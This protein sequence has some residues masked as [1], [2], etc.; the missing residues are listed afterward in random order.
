MTAMTH[1]GTLSL[2]PEVHML[3]KGNEG[4]CSQDAKAARITRMGFHVFFSQGGGP[5]HTPGNRRGRVH[6]RFAMLDDF[7]IF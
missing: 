4:M 6:C 3:I 5:K 1:L 7:R 2:Q